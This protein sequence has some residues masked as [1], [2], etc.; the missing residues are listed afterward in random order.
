MKGRIIYLIQT[1][2]QIQCTVEVDEPTELLFKATA[3]DTINGNWISI[4]VKMDK[5]DGGEVVSK[6]TK[7]YLDHVSMAVKIPMP[8][9][10]SVIAT[11]DNY[12][13]TAGS[14]TIQHPAWDDF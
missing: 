1:V 10:F 7:A 14:I 12:H 6:S 11:S 2:D 8:G 3:S 13:A 9:K 5:F 4:N